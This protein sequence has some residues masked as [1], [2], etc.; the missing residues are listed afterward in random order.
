MNVLLS[1][2][3]DFVNSNASSVATKLNNTKD[4][5]TQIVGIL[6]AVLMSFFCLII[7]IPQMVNIAPE[8]WYFAIVLIVIRILI[9]LFLAYFSIKNEQNKIQRKIEFNEFSYSVLQAIQKIKISHSED[10]VE[11]K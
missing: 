7:Y 11:K 2:T 9:S 1:Q 8:L 10:A 6:L 4:F 3:S 5:V